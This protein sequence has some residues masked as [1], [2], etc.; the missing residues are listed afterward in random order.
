MSENNRE[1]S[2][3]GHIQKDPFAKLLNATMEI[4]GPGHS[5]VSITVT[6]AMCNFHGTI[7]GGMIFTIADMAFGAAANSYGRTAVAMNVNINF[8]RAAKPGDCLLAEAIETHRGGKT[9]LYDVTVKEANS[10]KLI[11]SFQGRGLQMDEWFVPP[12][13]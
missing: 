10:G 4:V 5:K 7:H 6:E 12:E 11:A 8:V 2:I 9:A 3:A 13:K 1:A